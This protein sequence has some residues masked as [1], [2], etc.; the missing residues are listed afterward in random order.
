MNALAIAVL[1]VLAAVLLRVIADNG[2]GGLGTW[3]QAKFGSVGPATTS[4]P[5]ANPSATGAQAAASGAAAAQQGGA[6]I[7]QAVTN[8][9]GAVNAAGFGR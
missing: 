4:P 8:V 5:I 9:V 2:L 7:G 6:A 3:V 1:I